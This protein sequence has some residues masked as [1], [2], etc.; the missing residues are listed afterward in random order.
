MFR[1]PRT[2]SHK[3][4]EFWPPAKTGAPLAGSIDVI[5]LSILRFIIV[6]LFIPILSSQGITSLCLQRGP[7]LDQTNMPSL[8]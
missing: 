7:A 8:L 2:A 3:N 6:L 4:A 5:H 1:P